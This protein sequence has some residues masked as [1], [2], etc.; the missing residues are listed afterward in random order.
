MDIELI[1]KLSRH[2]VSRSLHDEF[3]GSGEDDNVTTSRWT[4]EPDR[5]SRECICMLGQTVGRP[6]AGSSALR[7]KEKDECRIVET[8]YR[9]RGTSVWPHITRRAYGGTILKDLG[10]WREVP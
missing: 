6:P 7:R 5:L 9:P 3:D 4:L 1:G 8:V 10:S 2:L